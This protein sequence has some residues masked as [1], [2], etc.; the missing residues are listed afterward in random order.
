MNLLCSPAL[1]FSSAWPRDHQGV[2]DEA[3][4]MM[5]P[6]RVA[7]SHQAIASLPQGTVVSPEVGTASLGGCVHEQPLA[8]AAEFN[9]VLNAINHMFWSVSP[10]GEFIRYEHDGQVGALAMS[11][12]MGKAWSDRGGALHRARLKGHPLVLQDIHDMFGAIPGP[13]DRLSILNE[14][15][16]SSDL[17]RWGHRSEVA[18]QLCPMAAFTT[19]MAAGLADSFPLA[20]GDRL[21]KKAQLAVSNIWREACH[22]G[23]DHPCRLTAFADY[24]IPNVLR[25][26]GLL[27]YAP[28][29]AAHID[30]GHLI[31]AQSEDE[32]AIRG[33][34][35]LAIEEIS[36]SQNV[37]VADV[38][39][40]IWQRRKSPT[41]PFHR[42]LT[43]AY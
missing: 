11:A 26:M 7:I 41:T 16:L 4:A 21:L 40:W 2:L 10:T 13:E 22:R 1:S 19:T 33:A 29:L 3:T 43:T 35:I 5:A 25:A 31:P 12:A 39:H 24:Q 9:I 18:T 34:S 36:A 15:L 27:T 8:A 37:Q 23:F 30:A 17:G 32:C 20:F 28:D 42:T 6:A 14:V 38:D